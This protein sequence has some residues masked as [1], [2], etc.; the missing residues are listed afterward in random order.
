LGGIYHKILEKTFREYAA[1]SIAV[2]PDSLAQAQQILLATAE[3]ILKDAP[4]DFAFRPTAWW[5]EESAEILRRLRALLLAESERNRGAAAMPFDFEVPFGFKG[6]P[7][8]RVKLPVGIIRVIGQI[9][10]IDQ[11]P[12]GSVTLIDYKSGST[13]INASQV[14]E[15]RN[16]QLPVYVLAAKAQKQRVA[17]AFFFHIRGGK[18]SG[19]V[20]QVDYEGW[21]DK[22][23]EFMNVYVSNAREGRFAVEPRQFENGTCRAFCEFEPLC[24]VNRWSIK[25]VSSMIPDANQ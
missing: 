17:D 7:A 8:L 14:I 22:A 24:R 6:K 21:I 9:D 25:T 11:W 18:S 4:L 19:N 2:T 23:K 16:L 13:P 5:R 1:H 20:A 15:G 12:D 3:P 10:R